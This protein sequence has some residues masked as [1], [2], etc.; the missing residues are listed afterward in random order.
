LLEA[1]VYTTLFIEV[2]RFAKWVMI[3]QVLLKS[4][5]DLLVASLE[6]IA[7]PPAALALNTL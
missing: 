3:Q 2:C 7:L 4:V 1:P 5:F 6:L